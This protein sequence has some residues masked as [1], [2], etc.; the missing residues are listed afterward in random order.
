[1]SVENAKKF[2]ALAR[3]NE[4]VRKTIAGFS[5]PDTLEKL[6]D[7]GL[8]RGLEFTVEEYRGAV[9]LSAGGELDDESLQGLLEEIGL[10]EEREN[11]HGH[12]H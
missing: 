5:G 8:S 3:R 12:G 10:G 9:V 2:L 4:Q 7:L 1:M 6:V 11:D